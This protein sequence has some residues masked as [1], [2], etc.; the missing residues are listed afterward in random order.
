[1]TPPEAKKLVLEREDDLVG[2]KRIIYVINKAKNT[3]KPI[4]KATTDFFK[5]SLGFT[6]DEIIFVDKSEFEFDRTNFSAATQE[7]LKRFARPI[8][9]D[10]KHEHGLA[11]QVLNIAICE[12]FNWYFRYDSNFELTIELREEF[13]L[14]NAREYFDSL[15]QKIEIEG[16][17]QINFKKK[18]DF[19]L[20]D[21]EKGFIPN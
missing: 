19:F 13:T 10:A 15:A 1:M 3:K 12:E 2:H 17:T 14:A 11:K 16:L 6:D 20:P 8:F 9:E 7:A 4:R 21:V 5:E 18:N